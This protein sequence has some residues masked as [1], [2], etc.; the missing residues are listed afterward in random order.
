VR[1]ACDHNLGFFEKGHPQ[2]PI[3]T[4]HDL[5]IPD[6]KPSTFLLNKIQFI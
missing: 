3:T 4:K 2:N 6:V 1:Y 5:P